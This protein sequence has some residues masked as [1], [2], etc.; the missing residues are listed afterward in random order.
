MI[1]TYIIN[2]EKRADR[3]SDVLSQFE[4]KEE[5]NINIYK[6]IECERG[7]YGLYLS[8]INIIRQ[9]KDR[10]LPYVL[11]CEDD[12]MFT[13]NYDKGLLFSDIDYA[14]QNGCDVLYGGVSMCLL[15]KK[16]RDNLYAV[17]NTWGTNFLVVFSNAYD[18]ILDG[19][20]DKDKDV[21]DEWL[22]KI[23]AKHF[24]ICP[25]ISIQKDYGYSDVTNSNNIRGMVSNLFINAENQIKN[26][27]PL[28][29]RRINMHK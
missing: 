25:F 28:R 13:S 26:A 7:A 17:R 10:N 15:S 2:L 19:F 3:L 18:R 21:L 14:S 29:R 11:I 4:G 27:A 12:H 16:V 9:A 1:E 6:A 23:L 5:F 22:H 24:A 20:F 8:F